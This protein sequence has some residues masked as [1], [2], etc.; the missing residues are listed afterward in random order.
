MP[1]PPSALDS[2]SLL[3]SPAQNNRKL[4]VRGISFNS[5]NETLA[6][7]FSEFGQVDEAT[8]VTDKSTGKSKVRPSRRVLRCVVVALQS[9]QTWLSITCSVSLVRRVLARGSLG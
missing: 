9:Y 1:R 3:L 5:T 7:A 8:I 6:Q 2:S 4:F